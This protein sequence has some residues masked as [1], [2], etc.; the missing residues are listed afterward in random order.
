MRISSIRPWYIA[1]TVTTHGADLRGR[2]LDGG[3]FAW[4]TP[5]LDRG[6]R[7]HESCGFA[8]FQRVRLEV[9][10]FRSADALEERRQQLIH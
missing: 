3:A 5:S 1:S 8:E 4:R 9:Q 6:R 7:A 10:A 2:A